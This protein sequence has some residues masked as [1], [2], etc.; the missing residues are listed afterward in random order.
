M[1][2]PLNVNKYAVVMNNYTFLELKDPK[3]GLSEQSSIAIGSI[4]QA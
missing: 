3:G 4:I 1:L 2:F